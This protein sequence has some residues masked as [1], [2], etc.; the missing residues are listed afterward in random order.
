MILAEIQ[1]IKNIDVAIQQLH[2]TLV[3]LYDRRK[4][5]IAPKMSTSPDSDS[6]SSDDLDIDLSSIDLTLSIPSQDLLI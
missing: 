6:I 1:E 2:D 5:I 4:Q 3:E